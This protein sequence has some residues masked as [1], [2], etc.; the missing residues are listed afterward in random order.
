MGNRKEQPEQPHRF[1]SRGLWRALLAATVALLSVSPLPFSPSPLFFPARAERIDAAIV[2]TS[3]RE[4]RLAVFDD[5]WSSINER[6]YDLKFN[7]L[8]WSAQRTTFRALAAAANSTDEFYSVLRRM[9]ASLNDSHTKVFAPEEK[10]DW[11]HPRFVTSG[12]AV[13]EV[14]GFPTVVEVE[15]DSEPQRA[16]VRAG[17]LIETVNGEPALSLINGRLTNSLSFASA[18]SRYRAFATVLEGTPGTS[19][20]IRWKG[21]NGNERSAR[22]QRYWQ[23]RELGLRIR[24]RR[25][26]VAVI[27]IDAFTRPVVA[28]FVRAL[29]QKI[30]GARGVILD[31][32]SNGGGD[33]EAMTDVA[34]A[35]LQ[36]GFGLGQFT[37]RDGSS[38][39]IATHSKSPFMPEPIEQT[40]LPL[41]V[42]TSERTASAA[43]ILIAAL[44]TSKRA[45]VIGTE[46]CGCVLAIRTR[47]LLP[48]GGLLDVS[49]LDYQ[50][51]VGERLEKHGI[52]P[53]ETVV[54]QR[55]DLYSGRDR[56]MELAVTKLTRLHNDQR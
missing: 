33:A 42:L 28:D 37:G 11:W 16:G 55:N 27:Q 38:F 30:A 43:E 1:R 46:T 5:A 53:D 49:E 23:Q 20:E 50:T 36:A 7:G 39:T 10:F 47:H 13:R 18:S 52:K 48:D 35:F 40:E 31:L 4:G 32:R 51:A 22:F 29:K 17:D 14:D 8:D 44:K 15:R 9:I 12:I 34:S 54:V 19:L 24:R 6:Y 21:K 25:G 41:V 2:S 56:A 26:D 45:I 3:T